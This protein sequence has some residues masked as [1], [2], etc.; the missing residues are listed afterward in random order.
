MDNI[1]NKSFDIKEEIYHPSTQT[2]EAIMRITIKN[3]ELRLQQ[4]V[5]IF[6]QLR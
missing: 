4:L 5:H 3:P 2:K 1:K 6:R